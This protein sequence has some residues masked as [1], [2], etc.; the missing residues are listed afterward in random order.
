MPTGGAAGEE[1]GVGGAPPNTDG[2]ALKGLL[3]LSARTSE[4]KR[5][6]EH[7]VWD[8][9]SKLHARQD[10]VGPRFKTLSKVM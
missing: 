8:P 7:A 2:G 10:G 1:L 5:A 4:L 3:I 6:R 9:A